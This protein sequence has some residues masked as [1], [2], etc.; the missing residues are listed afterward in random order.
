MFVEKKRFLKGRIKGKLGNRAEIWGT[1]DGAD[2]FKLR[3]E[4]V[5]SLGR[6]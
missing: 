2:I 4:L 1:A 5:R 6:R 3:E